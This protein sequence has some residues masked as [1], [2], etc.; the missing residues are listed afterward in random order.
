MFSILNIASGLHNQKYRSDIDGMRALAVGLV[1]I[2]HG[3]PTLLPGGF[4][5]VDIFFVLSGYLITSILINDFQ[6][7]RFSLKTFYERRVRRIFPALTTVLIFILI[8]SWYCLFST[9]FSLIGKHISA[10]TLFSENLLLWSESSYFDV[11]SDLKPTLH[12][13][14]LAIEEQFYIFLPLILYVIYKKKFNL[15]PVLISTIVISLSLNIYDVVK[16]PTAAYYSP[17]GRSWELLIGSLLAALQIKNY[18]FLNKFKNL[19]SFIGLLLILLGLFFAREDNFPGVIAL[20]PT[21]GTAL[22]ISGGSS[23][24]V[25]KYIFSLSPLVWL[26]IIS[27]P[28]YLWHWPLMSLSHIIFNDLST[29]KAIACIILSIV[30]AYLTF[31]FIE[32]PFREK[33]IEISVLIFSMIII[34]A[35]SSLIYF[36]KINSRLNSINTP[37]KNEWAFLSTV[38]S[39]FDNLDNLIDFYKVH[40]ER[41]NQTLFIGDSHIA[42][43]SNRIN[44]AIEKNP[45][46]N[47]AVFAIGGACVPIQNT[48]TSQVVRKGC[49]NLVEKAYKLAE[50]PEYSTVVI[51]AN[52]LSYLS[53]STNKNVYNSSAGSYLLNTTQGKEA[54]LKQLALDIKNLE[55][56]GKNVILI[57]NSPSD[58]ALNSKGWRIRLIPSNKEIES[59]K[60]VEVK[61]QSSNLNLELKNWAEK[62]SIKYIN[63][64]EFFCPQKN[65]CYSTDENSNFIFIDS[66]HL[67][68]DWTIKNVSF[69]DE[70]VKNVKLQ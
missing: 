31:L 20:L 19:Q 30:L 37:N 48:T 12:L 58:G 21:I 22:L 52:W 66:S 34:L 9:E 32:K 50:Q 39:D 13:W 63:P 57:L 61:S 49:H 43:Y 14:S 46:Y 69:I 3:F 7:E 17:F 56:L 11:S 36:N 10:S 26:G 45:Q 2:C 18:N 59:N 15:L 62:N 24:W 8:V 42:H 40:P 65:K 55:S 28:L 67:N 5:G 51:G 68:P 38:S 27:Y 54:A 6:K 23:S 47:G 1:L 4:I 25:N 53:N 35:L 33:R 29:F 16:N 64:F 41:Q 70:T 60:I 44:L